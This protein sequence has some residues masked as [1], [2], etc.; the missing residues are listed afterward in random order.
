MDRPVA[1]WRLDPQ[2]DV[3]SWNYHP[4]GFHSRA[5]FALVMRALQAKTD[6]DSEAADA[7]IVERVRL[8][9]ASLS[10]S[11]GR[12]SEP[13]LPWLE[14]ATALD[15]E[16]P[17]YALSLA[18]ALLRRDL[19][20]DTSKAAEILA[21]LADGTVLSGEATDLL[22]SLREQGH[23]TSPHWERLARAREN[24]RRRTTQGQHRWCAQEE[25]RV[26]N[27]ETEEKK[28]ALARLLMR[29][30]P[31]PLSLLAVAGLCHSSAEEAPVFARTLSA[32]GAAPL[33]R[34]FRLGKAMPY[35]ALDDLMFLERATLDADKN[36]EGNQPRLHLTCLPPPAFPADFLTATRAIR[37]ARVEFD[38]DALPPNWYPACATIDDLWLPTTFH[39][40]ACRAA[41]LDPAHL[42]VVPCPLPTRLYDPSLPPLPLPG[43]RGFTFLAAGDLSLR[44]GLDLLVTAFV[45]EFTAEESVCL[46]LK[47]TLSTP[48]PP[49][50]VTRTVTQWVHLALPRPIAQ[51]PTLVLHTEA[52]PTERRPNLLCAADA[53]VTAQRGSRI[54]RWLLEAMAMGLPVIGPAWG[55]VG[56]ALDEGRGI[57]IPVRR[58][59]VSPAGIW[60][61]GS[62]AGQHWAEAEMHGLRSALRQVFTAGEAGGARGIEA[63]AWVR[64]R[65]DQRNVA[66][67]MRNV[68]G[69]NVPQD[70]IF[71]M[72]L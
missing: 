52:L 61:C 67:K 28:A 18:Q 64:A 53:F 49:E 56:E 63:K 42:H 27:G 59:P 35:L 44:D 20:G 10:S 48:L 29:T 7:L 24:A 71:D 39:R 43:K 50:R 68:L 11:V 36:G 12:H 5:Y 3:F 60:E 25:Q 69:S 23:F 45:Q 65:H 4:E 57:A 30:N 58:T 1:A 32:A 16:F 22:G 41:G 13:G 2:D 51:M 33:L 19:P 21:R 47:L 26:Q 6:V 8:I 9:L 15:P 31:L 62:P 70:I 38:G 54:P 46:V 40:D 37:A 66:E 72:I 17:F 14:R 34:L 55:G